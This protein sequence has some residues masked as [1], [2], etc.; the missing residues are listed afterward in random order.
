MRGQ[1]EAGEVSFWLNGQPASARAGQT[2]LQA[3]KAQGVSIHCACYRDG[4]GGDASCRV[5]LVEIAGE[6]RLAPACHRTPTE[7]MAVHTDSEKVQRVRRT[8]LQFLD[9]EAVGPIDP[10]TEFGRLLPKKDPAEISE[11]T[12]V[13]DDS[14]PAIIV[15]RDACILCGRCVRACRDVQCNDVIGIGYRGTETRI[16]FDTDTTLGDSSCVGC[17][18]CV[19]ACPTHALR[20]RSA[21]EN[22]GAE[23]AVET[24][25]PYCGVG[26]QL[27]YEVRD[28][29]IV[30][31]TGL[32]GPSNQRRLCV[33]GRY[34]FDYVHHPHRRTQ[35]LIRR[36]DVPK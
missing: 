21:E 23:R 32:N 4:L 8:V 5:C 36:E 10:L 25:C 22:R 20:D 33:K 28:G 29:R 16:I 13:P 19:Q 26:C 18:E 11:G 1:L 27:R 17:G 3:A 12:S 34:G 35:P 9:A 31:A 2:V 14:H 6:P 24:V 15:D 30:A 7:G